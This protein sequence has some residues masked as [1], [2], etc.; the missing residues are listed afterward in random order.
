MPKKYIECGKIINTHGC[1]GGL[2]IDSWCNAPEDLAQ[3][4]RV[5]LE[6][7]DVYR[8]Y[9]VKKASI[10]KQFVLFDLDG[11]TDMDQAIALK[12]RVLYALRDDF[13]LEDGEYFIADVI[14]LPVID[15]DTSKQ[16][17]TVKDMVNRGASD[18]YIVDTPHGESMIP[19]VDEFIIKVDLQKGI[20]IRPIEGMFETEDV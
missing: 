16:Y 9:K 11:I 19:A 20:F 14:G 6:E 12:N 3:M 1:H 7:K 10:F 15:A 8:E 18:I 2:K 13:K 17:G 4:K 5:F